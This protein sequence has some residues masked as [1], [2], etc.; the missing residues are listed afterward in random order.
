MGGVGNVIGGIVGGLFGGAPSPP[1]MPPPPPPPPPMP[2]SSVARRGAG[3]AI[4]D[5]N[6]RRRATIK[7]GRRS[8]ILGGASTYGV[9]NPS[10]LLG[11]D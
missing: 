11:G 5:A 1:P 10:S 2:V 3:D 6:K 4:E 7:G 8:T 9:N